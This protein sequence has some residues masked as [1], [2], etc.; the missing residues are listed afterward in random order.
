[1]PSIQEG[2]ETMVKSFTGDC[3][4]LNRQ[5]TIT[6]EYV[7]IP[8]LGSTS[9]SYHKASVECDYSDDCP[10]SDNCPL[11]LSVPLTVTC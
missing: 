11:Y 3:P 9:D 5:H 1:M 2:D 10:L 4:H 8:I 7:H 6:V